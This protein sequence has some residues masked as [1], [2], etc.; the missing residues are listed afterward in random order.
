MN[1]R[2]GEPAAWEGRREGST[3]MMVYEPICSGHWDTVGPCW[4]SHGDGGGFLRQIVYLGAFLLAR[5]SQPSG[6]NIPSLLGTWALAF[7][8]LPSRLRR[9]EQ[10]QAFGAERTWGRKLGVGKC[11]GRDMSEG[12]KRG[13]RKL[14]ASLLLTVS[15]HVPCHPVPT[16]PSPPGAESHLCLPPRPA[17][18]EPVPGQQHLW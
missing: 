3:L 5:D 4:G 18:R 15:N 17:L 8:S 12:G 13:G 6:R 2:L 14:Q 16:G 10:L 7:T 1:T 9:T 11:L